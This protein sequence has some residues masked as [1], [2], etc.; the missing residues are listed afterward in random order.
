MMRLR[1]LFAGMAARI[2]HATHTPCEHQ[3]LVFAWCARRVRN[4]RRRADSNVSLCTRFKPVSE[5]TVSDKT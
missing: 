2:S 1:P 4:A 3:F 5:K